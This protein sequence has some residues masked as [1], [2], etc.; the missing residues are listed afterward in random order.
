MTNFI[1]AT[2]RQATVKGG[3]AVLQFEVKTSEPDFLT[4]IKHSG[5]D[6]MLSIDPTQSS[7]AFDKE[8][9]EVL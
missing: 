8:T 4:I 7:I 2:F 1:E 3:V 5:E 9:G 6:V